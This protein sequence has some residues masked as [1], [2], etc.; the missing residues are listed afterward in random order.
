MLWPRPMVRVDWIHQIY[1]LPSLLLVDGNSRLPKVSQFVWQ[2]PTRHP[3]PGKSDNT[4]PESHLSA[5]VFSVSSGVSR[6]VFEDEWFQSREGLVRK[7]RC[8]LGK[9]RRTWTTHNPLRMCHF[10][11]L[12]VK[13]K[14]SYFIFFPLW[15]PSVQFYWSGIFPNWVLTLHGADATTLSLWL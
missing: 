8:T 5:L 1:S 2:E 7:V 15:S 4:G 10:K 3:P 9:E 14:Q 13:L 11:P 12:T 6:V